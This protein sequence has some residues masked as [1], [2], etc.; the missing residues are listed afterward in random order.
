MFAVLACLLT[1]PLS[2][3][4][5]VQEPS[6]AAGKAETAAAE[7]AKTLWQH[8]DAARLK[9]R[10]PDEIVAWVIMGVLVG[11]VAGMLSRL[12]PSGMGALGRLVLGLVGAFLGGIAVQV[13][14]VDFG[15]GPVLIRYEELFFSLLGGMAILLVWKLLGSRM[16]KKDSH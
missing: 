8:I 15:W 4:E 16:K 10:T 13:F 7:E 6:T 9:N 3:A 11:A 12:K 2:A 5:V 14:K 1:Q